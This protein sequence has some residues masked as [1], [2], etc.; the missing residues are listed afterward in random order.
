MSADELE[1]W[2]KSL[3]EEIKGKGFLTFGEIPDGEGWACYWRAEDDVAGFLDLAKAAGVR[4]IY[5]GANSFTEED[6]E[7]MREQITPEVP[8][9]EAG[10][11]NG[12]D[13]ETEPEVSPEAEKLLTDAQSHVGQLTLVALAWMH[14][15]VLHH[16]IK[17]ASWHTELEDRVEELHAEIESDAEE[18]RQALAEER[19]EAASERAELTQKMAERLAHEPDFQTARGETAGRMH[20]ARRIFPDLQDYQS[21]GNKPSL[22]NV[23]QRAWSIF[24]GEIQPEQERKLAADAHALIDAGAT[25]AEA[26]RRLGITVKRLDGLLLRYRD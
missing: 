2:W 16:F 23:V 6:L 19:I 15:G 20:V 7:E 10:E 9:A 17:Q 1:H 11:E 18:R 22:N 26:A 8:E 3:Q 24:R 5:L 13:L 12:E 4:L 21:E 14:E 25:K